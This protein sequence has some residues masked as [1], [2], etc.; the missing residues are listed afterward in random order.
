MNKPRIR[1][2]NSIVM[3]EHMKNLTRKIRDISPEYAQIFQHR[4]MLVLRDSPRVTPSTSLNASVG[5]FEAEIVWEIF[6]QARI[7]LDPLH[8]QVDVEDMQK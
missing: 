4:M 2:V 3:A 7:V 8:V 6:R 5:F 1:A